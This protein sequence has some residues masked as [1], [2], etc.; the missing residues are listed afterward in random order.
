MPL[1]DFLQMGLELLLGGFGR[2]GSGHG[3]WDEKGVGWSVNP[4]SGGKGNFEEKMREV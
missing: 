1:D 2:K 3:S 4:T